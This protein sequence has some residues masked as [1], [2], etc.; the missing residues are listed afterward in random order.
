MKKDFN[1]LIPACL[2]VFAVIVRIIYVVQL[3]E[4][5]YFPDAAK[6]DG[7]AQD[8]LHLRTGGVPTASIN[9]GYPIFLSI[10]YLVFGHNIL[11]VQ[12][13]QAV[14]GGGICLLIY[15]LSVK[16]FNEK[17]GIIAISI[18]VIYPTLIFY[19]GA[20]IS[21]YLFTFLIALSLFMILKFYE[22]PST[23][24]ALISGGIL[25]F[26]IL[27]RSVLVFYPLFVVV[28]IVFLKREDV[29]NTL[30]KLFIMFFA[31][32]IAILP[33]AIRNYKIFHDFIPLSTIGGYV[34]YV[35]N[36]P[37]ADG[38]AYDAYDTNKDIEESDRET[39]SMLNEVDLDRY[40]YKKAFGNIKN[41]PLL[42]LRLMPKKF[43]RFWALYPHTT[44]LH[45]II[46]ILS[47]G[48]LLPFALFGLIYSIYHNR[49]SPVFLM[50]SIILYMTL[51]NSTLFYGSTRF[52]FPIEPY[53]II[54]ASY[55][56]IEFKSKLS[57]WRGN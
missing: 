16:A 22:K 13:I 29:V 9:P 14:M 35:S 30:G 23:A 5:Y 6:Y 8:I 45:K 42:M 57:R 26:A 36:H 47:F 54:F 40:Y 41:D 48:L 52:R 1:Y 27:T 38:T 53:L 18:S 24:T 32:F 51:I 7:F 50:F 4:S 34:F 39:V 12:I 10:I 2:I 15:L 3:G 20:L 17:V 37:K 21:E 43:L 19:S 28:L 11:A 25:G 44:T 49:S 46:S 56:L 33:W 31:T 55:G